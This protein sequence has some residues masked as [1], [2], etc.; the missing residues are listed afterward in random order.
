MGECKK[1]GENFQRLVEIM[2][3]LRKECPWD[4]EQTNLSIK[5]NLIE[6]AYELLEAIEKNDNEAMVE[7]LG[8]VLLQVI[9][10][11][12]IKKD[13]GAFDINDVIQ[14]LIEKL[15]RRHPH[16]FCGV[17]YSSLEGEDHMKKWE[18]LK[19][20]EKKRQSILDGIPAR[21]PA[22]MRA[23]KVQKRMAKVG[24]DWE[25]PSQV[26]EKVEE[27]LD[28][29]KKAKTKDEL[30]H[31]IGDLLIAVANL[32]RFYGIDPEEALHLSIDRNIN[33]FKYIEEK[34][35]QKGK[36]LEGMSLDDMEQYWQEAKS[37]GL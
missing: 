11:S 10:H 3:K 25:N 6:E 17:D 5:N 13:E 12:Q 29:L 37:K 2:E 36:D 18:M 21:M 34:A 8:D 16:V 27:E 14:N 22:L 24:F 30:V 32:A 9:F 15:I 28:E 35:K 23:V 1:E 31:E 7:E 33:R 4:K 26:L 19:Q 20:E